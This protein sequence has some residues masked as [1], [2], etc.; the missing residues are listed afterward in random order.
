MPVRIE[1]IKSIFSWGGGG[2]WLVFV[3][4]LPGQIT[5]RHLTSVSFRTPHVSLAIQ[6]G[7]RNNPLKIPFPSTE[8]KGKRKNQMKRQLCIALVSPYKVDLG[9]SSVSGMSAVPSSVKY[10]G[11]I[12]QIS[13]SADAWTWK[14]AFIQERMDLLVTEIK[15]GGEKKKRKKK[16]RERERQ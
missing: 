7:R 3:E 13:N 8:Q 4:E 5:R 2:W 6:P 1:K 16:R 12:L 9:Y 10:Q 15:R 11:L 14:R